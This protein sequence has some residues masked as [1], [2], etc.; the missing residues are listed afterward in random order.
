MPANVQSM[1]YYGDVPW[2]GLGTRVQQG[3]SAEKMIFTLPA[4]IGRWNCV[5]ARGAKADQQERG[6]FPV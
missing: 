1:A 3:I 2:H 6:V 4:W 5:L